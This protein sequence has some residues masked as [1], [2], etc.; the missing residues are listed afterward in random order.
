[1]ITELEPMRPV[2]VHGKFFSRSGQK[3]FMK[4]MR[5]PDVS[6]TLNFE[7]KVRLLGRLDELKQAHTTTLILTEAQSNPVLD[8][9]AQAGLYTIVELEVAP[10]ELIDRHLM[11]AVVSRVSHLVNILNGRPGLLGFL[12]NCPIGRDALRAHG[13]ERARRELRNLV[14]VIRSRNERAMVA[15]RHRSETCALALLEEDFIYGEV[16]A[17]EPVEL[18]DFVV[19]LHNIAE[20][21]PLVV[22]FNHASPGQ[23]EAVAVAFGAGAA[24][25]VAPPV[26]TP[27]SN[28]WMT[29]RVLRASELM[30]FLALN[31]TCPPAL[32]KT[33]M[34]SVVICAYN[35]ERTMRPCLESLRKL[36][37]PNYEVI[38][39]DDGSRD[40]T[41]EISMDFPEFRLIRQPNKGLSVAR[42]VGLHAARGEII[43]YTDS[44]CVVDPHWLTL[45]V[46]AMG[47]KGFDGCGG[48]NYAPHEEGWVEACCAASPGAPSH[49]LTADDIAE[50][51]AGCNMIYTK[52]AL[53]K[54]GGFDPQ[55]TSA[56]DDVDVCWRILDAGMRLGYCPA[57]FVWHFRRNTIKAYY[58]QQRG[59]GRA[60]AMLYARYPERFNLLGQIKW[61]GMIPGLLRTVPGGARKLIFWGASRPGAAT[62]FDPALTLAKFLPQTLEWT[63]GWALAAVISVALGTTVV[64]ALAMLALGP[65]WALYYAWHAPIEKGH[66]SFAA[67]MLVAYLAYT[68]PMVRAITRYKTL[69]K[70]QTNLRTESIPR[71]RPTVQWLKRTVKLAYWNEA[72]TPRDVLLDRLSKLFAKTGHPSMIESGWKDYDLEVRPSPFATLELKTADEEHEAGRLKNH[73]A[74]R[75]RMSNLSRVTLAA[76]AAASAATAVMSIPILAAG[77][78][79]LTLVFGACVVAAMVESGRLAYRAVEECAAELNLIPLGVALKPARSALQ[80]VAAAAAKA[81]SPQI[82]TATNPPAAE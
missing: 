50:H 31:G 27:A 41:A 7:Q 54:V 5:L 4:A 21:R 3:F 43:A 44:D 82:A 18:R 38:I 33:P 15:I 69:A 12:I 25:V 16:P 39:V 76:G 36:E 48:P 22:E 1:M 63:L 2:S 81:A 55:F 70:A 64:P 66:V 53:L 51:L 47:E 32:P 45:A 67:R 79:G 77:F 26:P 75:V 34:V 73:V 74:A 9:G 14:A 23:D 57:A 68:G 61:R 13:L 72:W 11:Q 49:V 62:V 10:E 30:P 6:A 65:I 24:G 56:G 29:A 40:R 8:L 60:E 37:Y 46:R 71:Q 20:A 17:L 80:T 42:N 35:A 58:G 59:Y 78:G 19:S 28:E 52:A